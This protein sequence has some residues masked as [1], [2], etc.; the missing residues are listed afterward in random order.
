MFHK[1]ESG[2]AVREHDKSGG[3]TKALGMK[4]LPSCHQRWGE[5]S[6]LGY[7]LCKCHPPPSPRISQRTCY[8]FT[9]IPLCFLTTISS[10]TG[11]SGSLGGC[12]CKFY[13]SRLHSLLPFVSSA[14]RER[15]A[16]S[17]DSESFMLH[18]FTG[19][20]FFLNFPLSLESVNYN[21]ATAA[22]K[23]RFS[24]QIVLN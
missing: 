5:S 13:S 3:D 22:E 8:L 2:L 6:P 14:I 24:M 19:I 1:Q 20:A 10:D 7:G 16:Y 12:D 15:K 4:S 9:Y 18:T 23:T 21:E 11:L 17:L